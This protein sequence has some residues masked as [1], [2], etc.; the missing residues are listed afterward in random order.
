MHIRPLTK[1]RPHHAQTVE[2][3]LD[4]VGQILGLIGAVFNLIGVNSLID[5]FTKNENV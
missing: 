5:L 4:I 3:T 2:V 1:T